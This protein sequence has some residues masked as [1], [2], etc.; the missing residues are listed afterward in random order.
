[1]KASTSKK[2][3]DTE[4]NSFIAV[5]TGSVTS[6]RGPRNRAKISKRMRYISASND[7][8]KP[9]AVTATLNRNLRSA[10]PVAV[11]IWDD[12]C[13]A[14]YSLKPNM[15]TTISSLICSIARCAASACSPNHPM[16]NTEADKKATVLMMP[17]PMGKPVFST[18]AMCGSKDV[19][20][21]KRSRTSWLVGLEVYVDMSAI[22]TP[23]PTI[24]ATKV[25]IPE[26]SSPSSGAPHLP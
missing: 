10:L 8:M 9:S 17:R 11:L 23:A 6:V 20:T 14:Q 18:S 2:G 4:R 5:Y 24:E 15:N 12:T 26:P 1:M 25:P 7:M 21:V 19:R 13:I 3:K 22:S 16:R